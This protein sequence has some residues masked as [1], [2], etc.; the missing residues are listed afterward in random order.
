MVN[1]LSGV[2]IKYKVKITEEEMKIIRI[3]V[4]SWLSKNT[5]ALPHDI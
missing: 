4:I 5:N 2:A 1:Q 3:T